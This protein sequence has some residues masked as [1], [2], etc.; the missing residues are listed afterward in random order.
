MERQGAG[1]EGRCWTVRLGEPRS[2][3]GT[4][5]GKHGKQNPVAWLG[6]RR[7]RASCRP[8]PG[9]GQRP[10]MGASAPNEGLQGVEVLASSALHGGPP[11][12]GTVSGQPPV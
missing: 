5:A 1:S 12:G 6:K 10:H 4:A 3:G 11:P 2:G 8:R 7:T 9:E